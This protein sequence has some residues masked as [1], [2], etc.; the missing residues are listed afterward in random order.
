MLFC[1]FAKIFACRMSC[2]GL[3]K[4]VL[5]AAIALHFVEQIP[6]RCI[7]EIGF[8]YFIEPSLQVWWSHA[9]FLQCSGLP[10]ISMTF[11]ARLV[12]RANAS[13]RYL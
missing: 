13:A 3:K 8:Q 12:T 4:S 6:V 10:Q 1:L 2:C 11:A 9:L 7:I 5:V